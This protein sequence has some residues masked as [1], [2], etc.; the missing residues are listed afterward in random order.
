[1]LNGV[2]LFPLTHLRAN[3]SRRDAR[4]LVSRARDKFVLLV[5]HEALVYQRLEVPSVKW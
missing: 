4:T 2:L 1:M 5:R 3:L